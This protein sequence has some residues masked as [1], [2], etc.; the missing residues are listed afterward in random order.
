MTA[1]VQTVAD[2]NRRNFQS[3]DIPIA[4][5][6]S[7]D[8]GIIF[9]E[10]AEAAPAAWLGHDQG[11]IFVQPDSGSTAVRLNGD[12]L[13]GSA[14]LS[15]G[16][17]LQV[18]TASIAVTR[19]SDMLVLTHAKRGPAM[20]APNQ[21]RSAMTTPMTP[22]PRRKAGSRRRALALV[23][24][25]ILMLGVG[26]VV[27]ATPVRVTID[28][29]PDRLSLTGFPPP[30]AIGERHLALPGTY[31]V[32]AE[33]SG[34][35]RL[36]QPIAVA[37]GDTPEPRYQM[38]KLPG[39]LSI[40]TDPVVGAK[41]EIDGKPIG[42]A[43]LNDFEIEA[44]SHALQVVADRYQ[45][46]EQTID[47]HGM[48][49]RQSVDVTLLPGWGTLL[50][51]SR[52]E[53]ATVRLDGAVIGTTPLQTEP[54]AGRYRLELAKTGW[55]TITYEADITA[56]ETAEIPLFELE[57]LDGTVEL[58]TKPAGATV[59]VNGT[60]RG[61]SPIN[62]VVASERD[63]ELTLTKPGFEPLSRKV[64]VAG[65]ALEKLSLKLK[66]EYGVVF[67]TARPADAELKVDG[68]PLGSASRRLRLTTV[69]HRLEIAK[70]G[71]RPHITT[72]TPRAGISKKID[73]RLKPVNGGQPSQEKP[74]PAALSTAEAQALRYIAIVKPVRLAMGASRREAGRRSNETRYGVDLSRPFLMSEK[75]V[76]NAEFRKFNPQHNSG[77]D[78]GVDL[79]GADSPVV[80]VSWDD[81][82][83][84]LN[85]LSEK[86]KLPPAYR[87]D[88]DKMVAVQP[89][90]TGYRLPT[91]AEWVFVARY[92]G[93]PGTAS[94][95]MKYPWGNS[96]PPPDNSGNYA[97]SDA[98]G[99]LPVTIK[100]YSDGYGFA[101]PVGQFPPNKAGIFDLGGNVAEWCHDLYDVYT[102]GPDQVLRDPLGPKTGRYHVVRGASWRHGSITELRL[103]YRDYAEKPRNDIGFRLVRYAN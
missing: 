87:Q 59:T 94:K 50:V 30:I 10:P 101:A 63:H 84:Y 43:P 8:G 54:M 14:W 41:V 5:G 21:P 76:T 24:F 18:G 51:A 78:R 83:R 46:H 11:Q 98:A 19:Q 72:V 81:A 26:F 56:S 17:S 93:Q 71:Y 96:L 69:A 32:V 55:K 39:L 25:A 64:R 97:D 35:H 22:S 16:D 52:P 60:F 92:E 82:A 80:S 7:P 66:P 73:V 3:S 48:H 86:D 31:R 90:T 75:E 36:D 95:P 58:A 47:V 29:V 79:N 67:I 88:G 37:F 62:L 45:P 4:L 6:L 15:A 61:R 99:H 13:E 70:P 57:K 49:Q 77:A 85:W 12:P 44:G 28:P 1:V 9:G 100:G 91:E 34:Y 20:V 33:K 74:S 42:E 38:T 53:G 102:G 2:G 68:K 40:S 27:I 103:S 23:A 65:G 89:M